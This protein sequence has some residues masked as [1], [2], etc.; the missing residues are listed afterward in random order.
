PSLIANFSISCNDGALALATFATALQLLYWRKRPT[1]IRVVALAIVLG[2][3]LATKF[4][5]PVLF[6]VALGLVL[7]LKPERLAFHPR[8]WN[9]RQALVL[10]GV[11][12]VFVWGV[13]FFHVTKVTVQNGHITVTSP[14]RSEALE[15]SAH[16]RVPV[17]F[18]VYIPAG[19]YL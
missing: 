6:V 10:L 11:S 4:S 13:Y 5:T 18:A 16:M 17:N 7:I 2:A 12:F 3:L 15:G 1:W 9:W 19:E 14:N 8:D